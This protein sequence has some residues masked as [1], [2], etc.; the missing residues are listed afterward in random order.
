M[1]LP[2]PRDAVAGELAGVVARPQAHVAEVTLQVVQPVGD[3]HPLGVAGEVVVE[4]QQP[5]PR[6]DPAV[7]VEVANQ[8][9][10]LG[11]HA[12]DRVVR[13][14]VV[15]LDPGDVLELGVAVLVSAHV[16]VLLDL[17]AEV[18]VHRRVTGG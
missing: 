4:S 18:A 14:Q 3:H 10:L 13:V 15:P 17:T 9:L 11:V 12:Q 1:I 8:L 2:P 7:A 16:E 5:L 6:I